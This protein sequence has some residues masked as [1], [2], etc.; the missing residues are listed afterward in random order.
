MLPMIAEKG[1]DVKINVVAL[2][3]SFMSYSDLLLI[4]Y[5][6]K[7]NLLVSYY[8]Y[9]PPPPTPTPSTPSLFQQHYYD[10]S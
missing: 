10:I 5:V 9:P 4:M 3:Y 1:K 6:C 7:F 2:Y 8:R